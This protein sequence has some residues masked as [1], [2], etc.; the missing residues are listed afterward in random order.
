MNLFIHPNSHRPQIDQLFLVVRNQKSIKAHELFNCAFEVLKQNVSRLE[1]GNRLGK[2]PG[3]I[4]ELAGMD[5]RGNWT[6]M[7]VFKLGTGS[8]LFCRSVPFRIIYIEFYLRN[9]EQLLHRQKSR[10]SQ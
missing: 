9:A 2:L 7:N 8:S 10:V 6:Y 4:G 3:L 5:E 1:N